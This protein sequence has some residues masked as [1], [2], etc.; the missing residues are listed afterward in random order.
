MNTKREPGTINVVKINESIKSIQFL[1]SQYKR[2]RIDTENYIKL[3]HENLSQLTTER[4]Y[5]DYLKNIGQ[6]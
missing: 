6:N 3:I 4:N 1:T 2:K 5:L